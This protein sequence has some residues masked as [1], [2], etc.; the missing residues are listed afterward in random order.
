MPGGPGMT[1]EAGKPGDKVSLK[2]THQKDHLN[3]LFIRFSV[4]IFMTSMQ[5]HYLILS[6]AALFR[7]QLDQ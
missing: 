4:I 3:I 5:M 1:G 2:K 6:N 7:A